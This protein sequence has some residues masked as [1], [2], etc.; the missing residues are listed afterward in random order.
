MAR[1]NKLYLFFILN[2]MIAYK[3]NYLFDAI[4]YY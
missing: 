1:S 2:I 3:I 4:D